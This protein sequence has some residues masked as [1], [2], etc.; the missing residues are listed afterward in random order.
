MS[1]LAHCRRLTLW[2]RNDTVLLGTSLAPEVEWQLLSIEFAT[3]A[4]RSP[5]FFECH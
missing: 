5:Q 3:V 1:I 4:I 2:Y